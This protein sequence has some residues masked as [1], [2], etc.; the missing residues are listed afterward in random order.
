MNVCTDIMQI[1]G[2]AMA[3]KNQLPTKYILQMFKLQEHH[4]HLNE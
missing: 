4:F 2:E 3:G 1:E